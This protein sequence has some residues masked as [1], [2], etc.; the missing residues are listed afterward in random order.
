MKRI[1]LLLDK[2]PELLSSTPSIFIFIF[3]LVYLFGFGL[4]GLLIPALAPSASAQ[5]IFGNYTNVISALGAALAAGAGAKHVKNIK[6]LHDK[7]D[8]LQASLDDL[9]SK[10]DELNRK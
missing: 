4:I 8:R 3:L 1:R 5:L 7:H 10:V 6:E 9:H 2:I